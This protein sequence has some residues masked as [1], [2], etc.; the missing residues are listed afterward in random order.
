[1][2]FSKAIAG[3]N[4]ADEVWTHLA[5][6]FGKLT[7]LPLPKAPVWSSGA[8]AGGYVRTV[9]QLEKDLSENG[10]ARG[11]VT[12]LT[13]TCPTKPSIPDDSVSMPKAEKV[14]KYHFWDKAM[15]KPRAPKTWPLGANIPIAVLSPTMPEKGQARHYGGTHVIVAFWWAYAQALADVKAKETPER[16][17]C[18]KSFYELAQHALFDYKVFK[19]EEEVLLDAFQL[20]EDTEESQENNGLTGFRKIILCQWAV[21]V[22]KKSLGLA[23]QN[24][25]NQSVAKFLNEKLR[26]HDPSQAPSENVVRDL[27]Q[28]AHEFLKNRRAMQAIQEADTLWGRGTVFDQVSKLIGLAQKSRG[29]DDLSFV[30]EY[31]VSD[32]KRGCSGGKTPDIP[33]TEKFRGKAGDIASAQISRDSVK[34]L[35]RGIPAIC[36]ARPQSPHHQNDVASQCRRLVSRSRGGPRGH[37][38]AIDRVATR[39]ENGCPTRERKFKQQTRVQQVRERRLDITAS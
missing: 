6:E 11:V 18:V 30:T 31:L 21:G 12:N 34:W 1:M 29:I 27:L 10:A 24:L 2:A 25:S 13:M 39:P 8:L 22:M 14:A 7:N 17:E 37:S 4:W 19:N 20:I 26:W 38:K 35:F 5:E 33:S 36:L 16:H 23:C 28:I 9:P 32:M 15:E 3:R